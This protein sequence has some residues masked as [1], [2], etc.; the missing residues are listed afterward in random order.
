MRGKTQKDIIAESTGIDLTKPKSIAD[1]TIYTFPT[2]PS[3]APKSLEVNGRKG[4]RMICVLADDRIHYR[5]FDM[6]SSGE[7]NGEAT[8]GDE[9][10]D[11]DEA[12]SIN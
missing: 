2:D 4:R 6:D 8:L 10:G 7:L 11:H 3:W 5:Q 12:M 9:G 1:C